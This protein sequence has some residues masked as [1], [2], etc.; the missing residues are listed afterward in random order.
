MWSVCKYVRKYVCPLSV[1]GRFSSLEIFSRSDHLIGLIKTEDILPGRARTLRTISD[2]RQY[3]LSVSRR[4]RT[5]QD[6]PGRPAT[7]Q[8]VPG[9]VRTLRTISDNFRQPSVPA[10]RLETYQD[11]PGRTRTYQDVP[12]RTRT[13]RDVPDHLST[14]AKFSHSSLNL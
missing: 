7:Y 9:R 12:G 10:V 5:Y 2:S 13:Y 8:D 6:V 11:V 1:P 14:S 3:P 4:T